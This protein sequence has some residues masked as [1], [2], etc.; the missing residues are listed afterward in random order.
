MKFIHLDE[1]ADL[2]EPSQVNFL[3]STGSELNRSF[4]AE[5]HWNTNPKYHGISVLKCS[6]ALRAIFGDEELRW[7]ALRGI[8]ETLIPSLSASPPDIECLRLYLIVPIGL[9][10]ASDP[11]C[12]E[13]KWEKF[14]HILHKFAE[15]INSITGGGKKVLGYWIAALGHVLFSRIVQLYKH[16]VEELAMTT[17]VSDYGKTNKLEMF[18]KLLTMLH[19]V[20]EQ[21]HLIN[22]EQFYMPSLSA[23]RNS[24]MENYTN[25]K[26]EG[27]SFVQL[28]PVA[29]NA[30]SFCDYPFLYDAQAK[31]ALLRVESQINQ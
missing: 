29:E 8:E 20:N 13:H 23:N 24:I 31:S 16:A 9:H 17:K 27:R 1:I 26:P 10:F 6:N 15:Q 11:V 7:E 18:C 3:F 21:V 5:D 30:F 25:W 14:S 28:D 19:E 4:L 12:A 22:Y 2:T